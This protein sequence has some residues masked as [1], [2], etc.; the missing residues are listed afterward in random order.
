MP[1]APGRVGFYASRHYS[2]N[3][4]LQPLRLMPT[5]AIRLPAAPSANYNALAA[6]YRGINTAGTCENNRPRRQETPSAFLCT[7]YP[8]GEGRL[9]KLPKELIFS[10]LLPI[11]DPRSSNLVSNQFFRLIFCMFAP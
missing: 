5:S 3:G 9:G 10:S 7:V 4:F 2:D 6:V 8:R 11:C 1:T